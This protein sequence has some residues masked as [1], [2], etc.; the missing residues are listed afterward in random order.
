MNAIQTFF[1][2]DLDIRGRYIRLDSEWQT[3]LSNRHYT[4]SAGELMGQCAAFIALVGIDVKHLGNFSLQMR[5]TSIVH[6]LFVQC[7]LHADHITMRG[8]IDA[9][10]LTSPAQIAEALHDGDLALTLFNAST[11]TDY[12]S[13][14]P[15]EGNAPSDIFAHYLTQSVQ[16]PVILRLTA[17]EQSLTGLLIEK[18]PNTDLKDDDG[19]NRIGHLV[20][21]MSNDELSS[22]TLPQLQLRLFHEETVSRFEP[23]AV[24]YHCPKNHAR[25]TE[26]IKSLGREECLSILAEHG[27]IIITDDVCGFDYVFSEA[28]VNSIFEKMH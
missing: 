8:M 12:Q 11:R 28:D 24:Q 23:V 19:W 5:G 15:I 10:T 27:K 17:T 20:A 21:S 26:V 16:Q 3:W 4:A 1:F 9:P 13:I 6:T 22:W 14:V 25:M 18:M 2:D 7:H